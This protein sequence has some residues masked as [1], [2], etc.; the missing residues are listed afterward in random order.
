MAGI[1]TKRALV[2]ELENAR[3]RLAGSKDVDI[4]GESPAMARLLERVDTRAK[5]LGISRNRLILEALEEKLGVR[6]EWTPELVQMLAQPVSSDGDL[7]ARALG[8]F[9]CNRRFVGRS[10]DGPAVRGDRT[11]RRSGSGG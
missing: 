5:T 10:V 6:D 4:V 8:K 3:A 11:D 1:A 2:R 7:A 9:L